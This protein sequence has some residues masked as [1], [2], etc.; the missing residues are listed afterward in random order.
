[1][2]SLIALLLL[3]HPVV[4]ADHTIRLDVY[5]TLHGQIVSDLT[6]DDFEVVEDGTP[7]AIDTVVHVG[8]AAVPARQRVFVVF[9]D[10]YHAKRDELRQFL[11]AIARKLGLL[12]GPDDRVAILTPETSSADVALTARPADLESALLRTVAGGRGAAEA[13][14]AD[15]KT[16][17]ACFE[18]A[19]AMELI[20]RRR[21]KIALDSLQDLVAHLRG[22]GDVRKAVVVVSNGWSLFPAVGRRLPPKEGRRGNLSLAECDRDRIMLGQIDHKTLFQDILGEAN[23]AS[24]SFYPL[25]PR[26]AAGESTLRALAQGT[27]G[28]VVSVEDAA[29]LKRVSDDVGSYY[30]IGYQSTNAKQDGKARRIKVRV[31]RPGVEVRTRSA[32]RIA[33]AAE[34]SKKTA[35]GA[36]PSTLP[37]DLE[38][39]FQQLEG[40]RRDARFHVRAT[41]A[42]AA[43][44]LS[45]S[46]WIIAEL[47][48]TAARLVEW[49]KGGEAEITL[50]TAEG[51]TLVSSG[52]AIE[53]GARTVMTR[54]TIPPASDFDGSARVRVTARPAGGGA[55][56]TDLAR[57]T[58]PDDPKASPEALLFRRGPVT[59]QQYEPAADPRFRRSEQVRIQLPLDG[60]ESSASGRVLNRAGQP[61]QVPVTSTSK[62][63]ADA[64]WIVAEL[65][66]A[67][68]TAGDYVVEIML[69][70]R[71]GQALRVPIRVVP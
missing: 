69:P 11:P 52:A 12:I 33:A 21:Q 25:F 45:A 35:A 26:G 30:V 63:D 16:Y 58:W 68:L 67:P 61:M 38:R 5:P 62:R 59:A 19:V 64:A 43:S 31:K 24:V 49:S 32:Y 4:P 10:T 13:Y 56:V 57:V 37:A 65:T 48:P 17:L 70:A 50:L 51:K 40:I 18:D 14:N 44:D 3:A 22:A 36:R 9:V 39:A 66:L 41:P 47:D 27:D 29:S 1:M 54:V 6:R 71:D 28:A 7:Q 53:P 2:R 15:E 55:P 60:A 46:A 34:E 8:S 23:H 20:A 42:P